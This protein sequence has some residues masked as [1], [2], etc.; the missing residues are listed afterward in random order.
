MIYWSLYIAWKHLRRK[1][2]KE[3]EGLVQHRVVDLLKTVVPSLPCIRAKPWCLPREAEELEVWLLMIILIMDMHQRVGYCIKTKDPKREWKC[4]I[5]G[6]IT[7][8]H[9]SLLH[10]NLKLVADSKRIIFRDLTRLLKIRLVQNL[11]PDLYSRN[12]RV[13]LV[14]A[15]QMLDP[16]HHRPSQNNNKN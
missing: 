10:K 6:K 9:I 1:R 14:L 16:K 2:T 8:D 3:A 12:K 5:S 7:L 13:L 11:K 15:D 4:Q